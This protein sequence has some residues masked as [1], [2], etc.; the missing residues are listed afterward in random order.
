MSQKHAFIVYGGNTEPGRV[1]HA[2]THAKQAHERGDRAEIYF[3][4]EGTAWPGVLADQANPMHAL[5]EEVSKAG[6]VKG[7]CENCATAFGN[8]ESAEAVCG[9][10]RGPQESFGQVDILGLNDS[11]WRVWLF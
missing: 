1:F 11:G 6:L 5:F 3:A 8:K 2:L 10:I 4:A 9:L 7:A